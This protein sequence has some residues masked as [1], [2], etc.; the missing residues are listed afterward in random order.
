MKRALRIVAISD[1][2]NLHGRLAIPP[3]D[4]LV[5]SGDF[6]SHGE[7]SDVAEFNDF[8]GRQPHR[9]KIVVAGNHDFCFERNPEEARAL[10]TNG[11]YLQDEAVTI[12]GVTFYGSPW[13]PWFYDWAFNLQR[14]PELAEKWAMIPQGTNVLVTHG[15]PLGHG[16]RIVRGEEVGCADLLD[17]VERVRPRLHIFGHIHE[18]A[19][20]TRNEH[21]TF[22]NASSCDHRYRAINPP[23]VFDLER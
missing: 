21:T 7:L 2:H 18:G 14:G 23:M 22:L 12:E 4:V 13:Q 20:L 11:H 3:G 6:T 10:L 9:Y 8:L 1:T 15:P 16:D 5:H 17:A 19:G